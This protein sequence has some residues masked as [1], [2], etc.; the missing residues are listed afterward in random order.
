[1]QAQNLDFVGS[2]SYQALLSSIPPILNVVRNWCH[3]FAHFSLAIISDFFDHFD[4]I[5]NSHLKQVLR[6]FRSSTLQQ[7]IYASRPDCMHTK[8][9][10]NPRSRVPTPCHQECDAEMDLQPQTMVSCEKFLI[11][12][13]G[14]T[15]S[16]CKKCS[17]RSIAPVQFGVSSSFKTHIRYF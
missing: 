11:G 12:T 2:R 10:S 14:R 17:P 3:L 15:N 13:N 4:R 8:R 5:S 7:C 9:A 6:L 16:R 1:M